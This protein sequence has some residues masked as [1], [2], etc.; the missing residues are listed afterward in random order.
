MSLFKNDKK[1]CPVCQSPTPKIFPTKIEDKPICKECDNK[2]SMDNKLKN[3]LTLDGLI[4][5]LAYRENNA[6]LHTTFSESRKVSSG[7]FGSAICI[8]DTNRLWYIAVGENSPIYH[9]EDLVSYSL[10]ENG[11]TIESASPKGKQVFHGVLENRSMY[12]I[13]DSMQRFGNKLQNLNGQ[14]RN[15]TSGNTPAE[16]PIPAPV[17]SLSLK[18]AVDNIYWKNLEITFSAPAVFDND[19]RRFYVD[20]QNKL[21]EIAEFTQALF[22]F[23][24]DHSSSNQ[25]YPANGA[26]ANQTAPGVQTA[27]ISVADELRKFKDLLDMNAITQA[28]F[29]QKKKELLNM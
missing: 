20:Y 16:Q 25:A 11:S 9:F 21:S 28:E 17:H 1:P 19:L 29:D 3:N 13:A 4:E 6:K 23:F 27:V 24:P 26:A 8:D 7:F 14:N 18:I 2:I 5:H 15:T 12:D 10:L 22:S